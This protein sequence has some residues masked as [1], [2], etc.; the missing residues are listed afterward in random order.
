MKGK[1]VGLIML[2]LVSILA[3]NIVSALPDVEYIKIN[4]DEFISGDQLEVERGD[5]LDI[6][7]K[8]NAS[9]N[10][11]DIEI[12]AEVLGYEYSDHEPIF[13][14]VHTFDL[15]Y[16]DTTYKDLT[17]SLPDKMD[18]DYYDLRITVGTRTG[19]AFEGLYRLHLKGIKHSL[20][21]KDVIFNPEPSVESGR[22]LLTTVRI[23]NIGEKDEEGIKVTV[24]IPALG[25]EASDY[26]DEL[27]ADEST[28]SEELYLRIPTCAEAGLYDILVS[29]EYDE[30]YEE[31]SMDEMISIVESEVCAPVDN[32]NDG[33]GKTVVTVPEAQNVVK[34]TSGAVFPITITNL[35]KSA[36]T[37]TL[38]VSGV[39]AFGS[40]RVD[41]S[42]VIVVQG[43]NSKTV[44]VYLT[45]NDDAGA[46]EKAFVV[47][48][49]TDGDSKDIALKANVVEPKVS[50]WGKVRKALEIG[51]IV[52]V[53]ILIII[54][55]IIGFSKL[56]KS[57]D[58]DE[59]P[60]D[61]VG[62]Q[63]YY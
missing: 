47:S 11:T 5:E 26:I 19:S 62:S 36:K 20:I 9:D 17:I 29:V 41:P 37:Y 53:V 16:G 58:E 32:G 38:S 50:A 23:K 4:G 2:F 10:E 18:K 40:Y 54:G 51:L 60:E 14:R 49:S 27:E 48:I 55:L 59:E 46:G 6:R 35:A 31:V 25:L 1:F 8:L 21:I 56:R 42:N 15:D 3:L 39:D 43:E 13:A 57:E 33:A 28:T 52:L 30:G 12:R 22:A 34:G 24:A 7:V 63:T 61:D 45:A 44:Y